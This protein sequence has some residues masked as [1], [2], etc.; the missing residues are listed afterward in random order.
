MYKRLPVPKWNAKQGRWVLSVMIDGHRKQ[1][2]SE[3][4]TTGKK[5]VTE[6][7]AA[8]VQGQGTDHKAAMLFSDVWALFL[9]DYI[10]KHGHNEQLHQLRSMGSIF[11]CPALGGSRCINLGIEDFQRVINEAKPKKGTGELSR[12]YLS[13]LKGAMTAFN[14]WALPRDYMIKDITGALYVPERAR[15]V[16]RSILQLSDV[17]KLFEKR[18][19]YNYERGLLLEVLTG[20]RPGEVLGLFREDYRDGCLYVSRSL[21]MRG[22]ITSG[23][24]RNAHRVIELPPEVRSIINE[25]LNATAPLGSVWLFPNV[26]GGKPS[27]QEFRRC[28]A[29]LVKFHGLQQGTTPYSLRHTFFTHTEAHIPDRLIKTIFGHSATTDSH[30]LYGEHVVDGERSE[31][32]RRLAV[33][34]LYEA[35]KNAQN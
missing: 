27:Q 34:P 3:K 13:N 9:E 33:T 11:L 30:H 7:A 14:R 28:W 35:A 6:R 8:W 21:N 31:A 18:A 15:T 12:K 4:K 5:E 25:Q 32:A 26:I 22:E 17:S 1:F 16:G 2:T 24:N 29:R 10:K 20:L 19:G 23:K